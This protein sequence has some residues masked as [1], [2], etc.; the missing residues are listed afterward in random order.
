M[1]LSSVLRV[2]CVVG[3]PCFSGATL[4]RVCK[5]SEKKSESTPPQLGWHCKTMR[6]SWPGSL[7]ENRMPPLH[8][9]YPFNTIHRTTHL[10]L[11]LGWFKYFCS[12]AR[13]L[14]RWSNASGFWTKKSPLST[15]SAQTAQTA[16]ADSHPKAGGRPS[17]KTIKQGVLDTPPPKSGLRRRLRVLR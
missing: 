1:L 12:K 2:L 7:V 14:G 10:P 15:L 16:G 3:A 6:F 4:T 17:K 9:T 11:G 13:S 5:T 8:V